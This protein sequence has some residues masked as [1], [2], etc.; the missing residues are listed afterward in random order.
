M[1]TRRSTF[2]A[3][4][5]LAVLGACG[6]GGNG[7]AAT[8]RDGDTVL[9]PQLVGSPVPDALTALYKSDL[10]TAPILVSEMKV[11]VI[12]QQRPSAGRRMRNGATVTLW[13]VNEGA[14]RCTDSRPFPTRAVPNRATVVFCQPA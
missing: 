8:A 7:R 1:T 4:V 2:A 12:A 5:V 3:C 14:P 13:L 10:H 6:N 11:F 9:V